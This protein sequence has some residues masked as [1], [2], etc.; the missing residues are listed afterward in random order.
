VKNLSD[1]RKD[2]CSIFEAG[3]KAADPVQAIKRHL[4]SQDSAL[5]VHGR[6]YEPSAFDGIYVVGAGKAAGKMAEAI[7]KLLG[8]RL[9]GGI[10]NVKYG[11]AVP[12]QIV[13]INQAG[14]PLPDEAGIRGTKEIM[15][16]LRQTGEKDL[17]LCLIS[18]GG[19]ALLPCPARGLTLEDK[20]AAT[21]VLLECGATICEINAVRKHIS[22]VKGGKLARLAYP[23][24]VVSLVLSD[25]IGDDLENI[26]SGPTVP[27][28]STFDDCLAILRRYGVED[29][30]PVTVRAFLERGA[31]GEVEETPK[32]GDPIFQR[33][34]NVIVGSNVEAV[35]AAETRAEQLGYHSLVLSSFIEG[36]TKEVAK[37]HAAIAREILSTGHPLQR[38]ACVVSGGETTVTVRGQ[39]LG[40]RNQEFALATALA[41]DGLERVVVLSGGTDGTDGPTDAAGA[42][43]DG[44]TVRRAKEIGLDV[45]RALK[46]ND[47]YRLFKRL[48]DLLITGPTFTNVMDLHIMLVG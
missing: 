37:V 22:E 41:I 35:Q 28:R 6:A 31:R 5:E 46:E 18:G 38:P 42:I 25:V 36:E 39:G 16:L 34:Q 23:S 1:L 11:H 10:V 2:A 17:V 19:S 43:A 32:A 12:L 13:T 3:L 24:S 29:K 47:S 44:A 27:D 21:K 4:R 33:V 26:A 40:G 15:E 8:D 14:H 20:Q 48:G 7:E 45:D 9:R 30:I